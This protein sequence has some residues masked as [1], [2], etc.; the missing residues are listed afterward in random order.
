MVYSMQVSK[1]FEAFLEV[2]NLTNK[3][4]A[5]SVSPIADRGLAEIPIHSIQEA[6]APSTVES[7]GLGNPVSMLDA[8]MV[9]L[10]LS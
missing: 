6:V 5:A 4:Y 2:K 1:G 10:Q 3:I 9:P 8:L 7:P